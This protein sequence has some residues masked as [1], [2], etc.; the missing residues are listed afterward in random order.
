MGYFDDPALLLTDLFRI[1]L[2]IEIYNKIKQSEIFY[3]GELIRAQPKSNRTTE[4]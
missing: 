2:H 3:T 4:P 1:G